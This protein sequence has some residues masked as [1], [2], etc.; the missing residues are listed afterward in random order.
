MEGAR[1]VI[2]YSKSFHLN[3]ET[4]LGSKLKFDRAISPDLI[5]WENLSVSKIRRLLLT[6]FI[7]LGTLIFLVGVVILILAVESYHNGI[8]NI[9]IYST[10]SCQD[11][12]VTV[13]SMAFDLKS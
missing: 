6:G 7:Y 9:P 13:T 1:R 4:F 11:A 8:E 2:N 3:S 12:S 5:R 10:V